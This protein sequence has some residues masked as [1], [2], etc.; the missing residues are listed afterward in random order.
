MLPLYTILLWDD[1]IYVCGYAISR[2]IALETVLYSTALCCARVQSTYRYRARH[3]AER[4]EY[5][6]ARR[7]AGVNTGRAV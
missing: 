3:G 7:S 4:D 2:R 1:G 5:P 6:H